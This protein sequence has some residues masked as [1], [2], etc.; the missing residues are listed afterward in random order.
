MLH[1]CVAVY[2]FVRKFW[3]GVIAASDSKVRDPLVYVALS[4]FTIVK[5][6]DL[7]EYY[8]YL[9]CVRL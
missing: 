6:S 2:A 9:H 8:L 5:L 3:P 4:L 1:G 7:F